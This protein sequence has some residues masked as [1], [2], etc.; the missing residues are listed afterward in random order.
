MS[1]LSNS[2]APYDRDLYGYSSMGVLS[3][4]IFDATVQ[5]IKRF[6]PALVPAHCQ[7]V[8]SMDGVLPQ[9]VRS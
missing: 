1:H 3:K 5:Q 4:T 2:F 7:K 6:H 8:D 9:Q